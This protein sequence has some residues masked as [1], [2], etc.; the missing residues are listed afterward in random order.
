MNTF[1]SFDSKSKELCFDLEDGPVM[2]DLEDRIGMTALIQNNWAEFEDGVLFSS[3]VTKEA[4]AAYL[5][6]FA[7]AEGA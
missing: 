3:D 2:V 1:V 5:A 4:E 7:T 6:A